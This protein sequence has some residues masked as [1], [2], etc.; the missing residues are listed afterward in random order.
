MRLVVALVRER[1]IDAAGEILGADAAHE[2]GDDAPAAQMVEH[3]EFLRQRHRIAHQRQRAAEDRDLRLLGRARERGGDQVRRRHQPVGGLMVLVDADAV[4]AEL[5]GQFELA[6]VTL[7]KLLRRSSDRNTNWA[8][9]P[10]PNRAGPYR[11]DPNPRRASGGR[12]SAFHPLAPCRKVLSRAAVSLAPFD[13]KRVTGLRQRDELGLLDLAHERLVA[14]K[15]DHA[16][17]SRP[18]PAASERRCGAASAAVADCA[19]AG[20]RRAA[21]GRCDSAG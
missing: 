18:R 17:R 8:A 6:D 20:S 10:R 2:T 15:R 13:R 1:R 9:S 19:G 16:D 14:G 7:V 3:G 11:R 21:P 12:R 4:E 5:V